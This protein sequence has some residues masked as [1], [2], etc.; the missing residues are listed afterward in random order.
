MLPT[1]VVLEGRPR[2]CCSHLN[3]CQWSPVSFT[4]SF[5]LCAKQHDALL[6]PSTPAFRWPSSCSGYQILCEC[7]VQVQSSQ[8][9]I[10][11][12]MSYLFIGMTLILGACLLASR[13]CVLT[14]NFRRSHKTLSEDELEQWRCSVVCPPR[15]GHSQ[16]CTRLMTHGITVWIC[17]WEVKCCTNIEPWQEVEEMA[18]SWSQRCYKGSFLKFSASFVSSQLL[19]GASDDT[20]FCQSNSSPCFVSFSFFEYVWNTMAMEITQLRCHKGKFCLS[21]EWQLSQ[22]NR[23]WLCF[24]DRT[25]CTPPKHSKDS[26]STESCKQRA[27]VCFVFFCAVESRLNYILCILYYHAVC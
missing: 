15:G 12:K 11:G 20:G 9:A 24:S 10:H 19:V 7:S 26:V 6:F 18:R 21:S 14:R 16:R 4:V 8:S 2:C 3:V 13:L 22:Q 27:N 17:Y 25:F 23:C 5:H 1:L